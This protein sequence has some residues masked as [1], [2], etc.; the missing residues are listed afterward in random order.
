[1][2]L[3]T[4]ISSNDA[5]KELREQ[6]IKALAPLIPPLRTRWYNSIRIELREGT[7]AHR[8]ENALKDQKLEK[9]NAIAI[10]GKVF[11][12]FKNPLGGVLNIG[13]TPKEF[14]PFL[15]HLESV[16]LKDEEK[17]IEGCSVFFNRAF[18]STEE[19]RDFIY[20]ELAGSAVMPSVLEAIVQIISTR[21]DA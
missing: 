20:G 3:L 15:E 16:G 11:T 5:S 8:F 18:K 13:L 12:L 19:V 6:A 1:M 4:E 2:S 7:L 10:A 9:K 17:L 21:N 14:T